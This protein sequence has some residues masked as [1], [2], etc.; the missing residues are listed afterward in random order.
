MKAIFSEYG[1]VIISIIVAGAIL[2]TFVFSGFFANLLATKGNENNNITY[3]ESDEAFKSL[4][5][6][7]HGDMT[8]ETKLLKSIDL[9]KTEKDRVELLIY[10]N[11]Y[12][13]LTGKGSASNN[14][15]D[16]AW[17]WEGF[18][19]QEEHNKFWGYDCPYKVGTTKFY[20]LYTYLWDEI[21]APLGYYY[22]KNPKYKIETLIIE[23]GIKEI[24]SNL[25]NCVPGL[26][27]VS[28]ADSV[29]II[30]SYGF[31]NNC[32]LETIKLPN[33]LKTISANLFDC[34]VK[35][36]EINIPNAVETIEN[37]AFQGCFGLKNVF[38]PQN[39]KNISTDSVFP[40]CSNLS[41]IKVDEDNAY[42]DSRNDC[43]AIIHTATNSL[44]TGCKNTI[45]PNN[46]VCIKF[47]AFMGHTKLEEISIPDSVKKIE[48]YAFTDCYRL[49]KI[50]FPNTLMSLGE[51]A[52]AYTAYYEDENNWENDTLYVDNVLVS[53]NETN[54]NLESLSVKEGI[55]CIADSAHRNSNLKILTIADS[56]QYIGSNAFSH[57]SKLENLTIP[58]S[59]KMNLTT[60][61]KSF[62]TTGLKNLTLTV[63]TGQMMALE[64]TEYLYTPWYLSK[65]TLETVTVQDG[66][67]NISKN[68]FKDCKALTT[69][70]LP[71]SITEI[72]SNAFTGMAS[73]SVIYCET[74]AVADL[75]SGKYSATNTSIVV[76]ST[77]F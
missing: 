60:S 63:G 67:K 1:K 62:N 17:L 47:G 41:S 29:N 37:C 14:G 13:F 34:C 51:D 53:T 69:V 22:L 73:G 33:N 65:N 64:G 72:G 10:D 70:K 42:Y 61:N 21:E 74:Q 15:V 16:L 58:C 59:A 44:V 9:S 43:N 28:I 55:T 77:I 75:L 26:K 20:N 25:F 50:N 38:I 2:A 57:C 66:V 3:E 68:A 12:A 8:E 54:P 7:D 18:N 19:S 23:D 30:G 71:K 35:L 27:N 31:S 48:T 46:V 45:I 49:S 39:V 11:G 24:D 56:I 6:I 40:Y 52:I 36:T 32:T 4:G 5:N 76:D